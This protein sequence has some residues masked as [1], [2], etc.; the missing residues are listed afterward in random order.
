MIVGGNLGWDSG[1]NVGASVDIYVFGKLGSGDDGG[2]DLK[3][4]YEVY[5]ENG[6]IV[7]KYVNM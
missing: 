5:Y 4:E 7:S 2:Y 3:V 1:R 6:S